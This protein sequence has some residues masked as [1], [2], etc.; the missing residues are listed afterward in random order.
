MQDHNKLGDILRRNGDAGGVYCFLPL[1]IKSPLPIHVNGYWEI[2]R[3]R[4]SMLDSPDAFGADK[5]KSQWNRTLVSIVKDCYLRVL[6][7]LAS[8][9]NDETRGTLDSL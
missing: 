8:Q 2:S 9:V 6:Q 1:P 4:T 5:F 7:V 3:D